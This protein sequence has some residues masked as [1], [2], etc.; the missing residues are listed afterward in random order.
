MSTA[1]ASGT[2]PAMTVADAV[3]RGFNLMAS[4]ILAL[5]GAAFSELIF[6]EPDAIDKVDNSVLL[7]VGI[8]A[9]V[10][11]LWG[12]QQW[13]RTPIPLV[14][15]GVALLGQFLGIG[16]EIGDSAAVG[17]DFGGLVIYLLTMILLVALYQY[18]RRYLR[19]TSGMASV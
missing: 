6:S 15:S 17:D 10:W 14:F 3:N 9:V 1:S 19:A 13:K 11:Y 16:I 8:I 4:A 12:G 18:N 5:A 7:L 2:M